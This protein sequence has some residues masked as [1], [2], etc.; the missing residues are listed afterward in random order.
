VA[1][2]VTHTLGS[3]AETLHAV[4][5]VPGS[6]DRDAEF[7]RGDQSKTDLLEQIDRA[8]SLLDELAPRLTDDRALSLTTLPTLPGDD[9]RSGWTWLV[10][11]LGHA[12]EHMGHLR[13]TVQLYDAGFSSMGSRR[14]NKGPSRT[15]TKD[16]SQ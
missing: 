1:T 13:L 11:N 14:S 16:S 12:R 9:R 7:D 8:V 2:I 3:E 10:Q 4:A 5:G 15:R 6:R